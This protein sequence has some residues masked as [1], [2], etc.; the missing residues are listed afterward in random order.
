MKIYG[1]NYGFSKQS[2]GNMIVNKKAEE[3]IECQPDKEKAE[4]RQMQKELE[5]S[6]YWDLKLETVDGGGIFN[7]YYTLVNKKDPT[8]VHILGIHPYKIEGYKVKVRSIVAPKTDRI[9][10]L[11]FPNKEKAQKLIALQDDIISNAKE[12]RKRDTRPVVKLRRAF[13]QLKLLDE[14]YGYMDKKGLIQSEPTLIDATPKGPNANYYLE[15]IFDRF[16][17]MNQQQ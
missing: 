5:D 7:F 4:I 14:A 8:N 10:E 12:E 2:F 16:R 15:Y 9:E 11:T 3:L 1:G 6:K 13:E 17:H